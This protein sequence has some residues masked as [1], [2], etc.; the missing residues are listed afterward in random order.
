MEDKI[1]VIIPAYNVADTI[2]DVVKGAFQHVRMVMVADDGS[3][4]GTGENALSAGANVIFI[5]RNRG[6]GNALKVLFKEAAKQGYTAVISMDG[7]GQHNPDEIPRLIHAHK[8]NPGNIIVGSRMHSRENIPRARYNSM[9]VAR[10]FISLA[11][12]QFIEDT[13]CGYRVYPLV[14]IQR[15]ALTQEKYVTESEILIKAGDMGVDIDFVRIGA[16]YGEIHSHFRPV[17]DV[18]AITAYIISY[19]PLKFFTEA[20]VPGKSYTYTKGNLRDQIARHGLL[21][22]LYKVITAVIGI[23]MTVICLVG[24]HGLSILLGDN[25]TSVRKLGHGYYKITLAALL[26]PVI[27]VIIIFEKLFSYIGIKSRLVDG[28]IQ[29]FYPH[30]WG[31]R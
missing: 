31:D 6:K 25:F 26:L 4:D 23:P 15:L 27:L 17:L 20:V 24:Y 12:N 11:A 30:L 19:F 8:E 28:I 29:K 2:G 5:D 9:H 14:L 7:D 13:Q 22:N 1:C 16:I 10:F 18:A 3:G 21:D